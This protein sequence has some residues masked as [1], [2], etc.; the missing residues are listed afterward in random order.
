MRLSH[1]RFNFFRML[2][3]DLLHKFELGVWKALFIHLLIDSQTETSLAELDQQ[4]VCYKST[5]YSSLKFLL[6]SYRHVPKFGCDTIQCFKKN[7]SEMKRTTACD[8]EDLLQVNVQLGIDLS[9]CWAWFGL[10]CDT[11]VW[12]TSTR[13]PQSQGIATLICIVPL[14]QACKTP[15]AYWWYIGHCGGH[16]AS[17]G[18]LLQ[19]FRSQTC[20]A[21]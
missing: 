21:F 18:N 19:E 15:A 16:D 11:C 2:I 10:V 6:I 14:A 7:V 17:V 8:F 5:S 20:S 4:W 3:V 12:R 13:T 1:T 9:E